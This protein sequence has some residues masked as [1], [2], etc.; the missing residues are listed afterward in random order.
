MRVDIVAATQLSDA[1]SQALDDLDAA[2]YPNRTPEQEARDRQNW[3]VPQWHILISDGQGQLVSH[4]GLV[5]R[6]CG[7]D[8]AE[9][10][11]G[12]IGGVMTHP[13]QR[14]KGY[15]GAGLRQ[16]IQVLEDDMRVDLSLLFCGPQMV[17][18]YERF[19]FSNYAGD[20][21]V[22][23]GGK[24]VLFPRNEVMVRPALKPLPPGA[25]LDLRG[26]PW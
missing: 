1:D 25:A 14:R 10:L 9:I 6:L 26:L 13:A 19:G 3:A 12:G 4:V 5:T 7:C 2:V 21:F 24:S 16:A 11:I 8:G 22:R 20:T 15:A 18:Y 23:R 17:R